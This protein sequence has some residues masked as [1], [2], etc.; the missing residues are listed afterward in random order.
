[1]LL[2]LHA[3]EPGVPAKPGVLEVAVLLEP[4]VAESGCAEARRAVGVA[5]CIQDAGEEVCGEGCA[6]RVDVRTGPKVGEYL[7]ELGVVDMGEALSEGDD[8]DTSTRRVRQRLGAG[9]PDVPGR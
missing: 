5:Y 7:F 2:E 9:L 1:M 4:G 8:R 3:V 6:A